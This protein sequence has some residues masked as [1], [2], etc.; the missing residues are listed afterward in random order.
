MSNEREVVS[1]KIDA[2][3]NEQVKLATDDGIKSAAICDLLRA[4]PNEL[5]TDNETEVNTSAE[6]S[7]SDD[8]TESYWV[9]WCWAWS[10]SCGS[11]RH[12]S[13]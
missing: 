10:V 9:S 1:I 8:T 6:T 3:L 2:E 13:A 4:D 5:A 12:Y 11:A 7:E